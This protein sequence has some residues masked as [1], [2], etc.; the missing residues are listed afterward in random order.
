M[1]GVYYI[2]SSLF[3]HLSALHKRRGKERGGEAS[4]RGNEVGRHNPHPKQEK[5]GKG[6]KEK[7]DVFYASYFLC[8]GNLPLA[9]GSA[10]MGGR[11]KGKG[12][13]R[14]GRYARFSGLLL[15]AVEE[16]KKGRIVARTLACSAQGGVSPD[17]QGEALERKGEKSKVFRNLLNKSAD[18][19]RGKR[20]V[21]QKK[22]IF[23]DFSIFVLCSGKVEGGGEKFRKGERGRKSAGPMT[24]YSAGYRRSIL[25]GEEKDQKGGGLYS[26]R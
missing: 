17:P 24:R 15:G 26:G 23:S 16:A 25:R 21:P 14:R 8:S 20:G 9:E 22:E 13:R 2:S 5:E 6:G 4:K 12:P 18:V 10:I 3:P 7:L 19:K 11:R 1:G